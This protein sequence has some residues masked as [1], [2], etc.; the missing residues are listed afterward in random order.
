[1]SRKRVGYFEGT[2]STLL[3]YLICDGYDTIPIS[4]GL[5][6]HG[7]YVRRINQN[8]RFDLLV[9]YLHKICGPDDAETQY[10]D[11]FHICR[12]FRMPLLLEVPSDLQEQARALLGDIPEEVQF[13]DPSDILE[14]ALAILQG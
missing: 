11:I 5:D 12:A 7:R 8:N 4:N 2:D 10:Q 1:V 3:T 14:A 9:G 13:V 6:N